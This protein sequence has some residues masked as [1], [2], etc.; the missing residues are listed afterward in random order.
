MTPPTRGWKE[1]PTGKWGAESARAR[2]AIFSPRSA[3]LSISVT[4]LVVSANMFSSSAHLL[5]L[6]VS[7][8][9]NEVTASVTA[10]GGT[11]A[12][13]RAAFPLCLRQIT[14]VTPVSTFSR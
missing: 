2:F 13:N 3:N 4:P 6:M 5:V 11:N 8:A 9:F 14:T 1:Q 10:F 12:L 7:P